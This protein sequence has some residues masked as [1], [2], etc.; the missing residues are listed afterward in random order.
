MKVLAL[1]GSPRVENSSTYHI[2]KPLLE[3]MEKAG[4]TTEVIHIH[5]LHLKQC[6]GCYS[7]WTRTPGVCVHKDGMADAIQKYIQADF[8]IFGTPLYFSLMSGEMKT[9]IDR[10]LILSEPSLVTRTNDPSTTAHPKRFGVK[11]QKVL[12]VSPCGFPE[13]Q[14]FDAL[15]YSFKFLAS[16]NNWTYLGEILRSG[17]EPLAQAGLQPFFTGYYTL[18]KQAGEQLVREGYI[19]DQLQ[20]E[21]RKD[22][23]PVDKEKFYAMAETYW[24]SKMSASESNQNQST[25]KETISMNNESNLQKH[26]NTLRDQM[27]KMPANF[28]PEAAGDFH[29]DIQ[30]DFSGPDAGQYYLRIENGGCVLLDGLSAAPR[31]TMHISS[32]DWKAIGRGELG[33]PEAFMSGKLKADGD[34]GLMM[35]WRD[36]FTKA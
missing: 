28:L 4:A 5:Q 7:C 36:F 26:A 23:F 16:K 30:F 35:K 34:F 19:S 1:N 17:A 21:L 12:L 25:Y 31:L 27:A 14:N 11:N 10:L 3:G 29:G 24:K 33:G 9:F 22:L 8:L 13:Y 32:E 6:L 2:L 15:V 18:L 20:Q